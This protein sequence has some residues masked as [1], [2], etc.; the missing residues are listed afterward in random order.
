MR[1]HESLEDGF[2]ASPR[3]LEVRLDRAHR[4]RM[5]NDIHLQAGIGAEQRGDLAGAGADS[6]ASAALAVAK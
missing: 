5:P 4:V 2:G 1:A 3:E 6:G